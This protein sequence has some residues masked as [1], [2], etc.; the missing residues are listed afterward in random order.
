MLDCFCDEKVLVLVC[1]A[2]DELKFLFDYAAADVDSIGDAGEIG[3]FEFDAGALVAV[4]EENV[5]ACGGEVCGDVFSGF[6]EGGVTDVGDG[7]DDL[8]GGDG[9]R[10]RVGVVFP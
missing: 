5:E 10:E 9:G 7:D 8:E 2:V 1:E 3:V 4:V 6:E